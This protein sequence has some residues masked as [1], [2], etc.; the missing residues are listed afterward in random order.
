[1]RWQKQRA[2]CRQ[3]RETNIHTVGRLIFEDKI[4]RGF[5]PSLENIYPR[6]VLLSSNYINNHFHPRKF[7]HEN[8]SL[9]QISDDPRNFISSKIS[10]PT[11]IAHIAK[12]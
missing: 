9:K 2:K 6:N 5:R 4:F 7:I 11:V 10:R 12:M 1:M 3:L 8:F